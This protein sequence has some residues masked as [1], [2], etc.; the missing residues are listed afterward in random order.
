MNSPYILIAIGLAALAFLPAMSDVYS[1]N[2][3]KAQ[4]LSQAYLNKIIMVPPHAQLYPKG[5]VMQCAT[6]AGPA[7]YQDYVPNGTAPAGQG[8]EVPKNIQSPL[9]ILSYSGGPIGADVSR[10]QSMQI[11]VKIN[12]TNGYH[13]NYARLSTVDIPPHVNAWIDPS[14]SDFFKHDPANQNTSNGTIYVY[15]DS[16]AS[17]G[18]YDILIDATG[19]L[20]SPSG[21]ETDLNQTPIGILHLTVSGN[22][23]I[24]LDAGLPD[25]HRANVCQQYGHGSGCTSFVAYEEYPITV[26]GNDQKVTLSAPDLPAGK[27]LRFIPNQTIATQTGSKVRMVT[28]GI[29]TP[30][31]PNALFTPVV[32][33]VA[34]SPDGTSASSYIP[35]AKGQN[36]SIISSPQKIEFDGR[37]GGNGHTGSGIFGVIYNPSDYTSNP[38]P[39]KLSVLGMQNGTKVL[40]MPS[41]LSVSIHDSSFD[42]APTIPYF[43]T[44]NFTS[45][46]A[47]LGTYPVA[48]G[49][50]VG[51]STFVQD[52]GITIYNPPI[53]GPMIPALPHP[54]TALI[55]SPPLAQLRSGII[56]K[57]VTC[58]PGLEL[59]T[60]AENDSPACVKPDT[61]QILIERGWAK[62]ITI[63]PASGLAS[64]PLA[65]ARSIHSIWGNSTKVHNDTDASVLAGYEV[66][67][68]TRLPSS[69]ALQLAVMKPLLPQHRYVYLFYS[70]FPISKTM[71]VQ[72]FWDDKGIMIRYD[73]NPYWTHDPI[74]GNWTSYINGEKAGGYQDAHEV[75]V[76]GY[77][78]WAGSNHTGNIQGLP[79]QRPSVIE[80]DANGVEVQI[81]GGIPLP[82]L[83]AVA[84]S[85]QY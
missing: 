79:I 65:K 45:V 26:Y 8:Q 4:C 40:P 21:N 71:R 37:F 12:V 58:K 60:K 17:S 15:V 81:T 83:T 64:N 67:F 6:K 84:Q 49:E 24:W 52:V 44:I 14:V 13:L 68:P 30:G 25:I 28:S 74:Y 20:K 59:V 50:D 57:D 33:L 46:N 72:D 56:S 11:P 70:K 66:R 23:T 39:V 22:A 18:T 27:Y 47:S 34:K 43:F 48:I 42:L 54:H 10:G 76:N 62:K 55:G 7:I 69:Y 29:V 78:G 31:V 85:I 36:M 61:A 75:T 73:Y 80:Y 3:T 82:D 77:S 38:L 2:S 51:G 41:W 63:Q 1:Q 16:A 32:T 53:M 19:S 35:I 9:Q 5:Y